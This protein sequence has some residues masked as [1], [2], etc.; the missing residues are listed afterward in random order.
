MILDKEKLQ[1]YLYFIYT[2]KIR[3]IYVGET[4]TMQRI[5]IYK[6]I[7]EEPDNYQRVRLYNFYTKNK[8]INYDL[9]VDLV[10]RTNEFKI[11][12][13]KTQYHKYL[14]KAYIKYLNDNDYELYNKKL[15]KKFE[16]EDREIDKEIIC[17]F[18][19]IKELPSRVESNDFIIELEEDIE[20]KVSNKNNY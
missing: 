12:F 9:A 14:E 5:E 7:I 18:Q 13:M 20:I 16:L 15:Y 8:T 10:D 19:N 2:N 3:K 1:G 6:S 4:E 11:H 17:L